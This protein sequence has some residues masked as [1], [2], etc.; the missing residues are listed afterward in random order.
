MSDGVNFADPGFEASDEDLQNL[1]KEAFAGAA[2]ANRRALERVHVEI[3]EQRRVVLQQ[4]AQD[5]RAKTA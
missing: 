5:E 4:V 2:A 1:S 3:Q